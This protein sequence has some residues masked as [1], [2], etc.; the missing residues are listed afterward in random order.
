MTCVCCSTSWHSTFSN[1]CFDKHYVLG[2]LF[3]RVD[4]HNVLDMFVQTFDF[5]I[6]I[7]KTYLI[8]RFSVQQ[9]IWLSCICIS[10]ATTGRNNLSIIFLLYFLH[11]QCRAYEFKRWAHKLKVDKRIFQENIFDF[12]QH[13]VLCFILVKHVWLCLI[14]ASANACFQF[15]MKVWF[16]S[17]CFVLFQHIG[18]WFAFGIFVCQHLWCFKGGSTTK[19]A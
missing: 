13:N 7:S 2:M 19:T 12:S 11:L 18:L 17:L 9:L 15:A 6:Q 4:K 14:I 8:Y 16:T 5:L 1:V 3:Q 10:I